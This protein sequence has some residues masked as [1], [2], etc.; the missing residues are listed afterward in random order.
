MTK[1]Q[2]TQFSL[3][4]CSCMEFMSEIMEQEGAI[5]PCAEMMS[6]FAGRQEAGDKF[7]E[8]MSQMFATCCGFQLETEPIAKK[9]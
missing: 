6:Q 7:V 1:K 8:M 5:D 4:D 9:V 2:D 3:E